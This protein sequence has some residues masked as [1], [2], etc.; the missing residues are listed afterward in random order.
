MRPTRQSYRGTP[1]GHNAD[2]IYYRLKEPA[3]LSKAIALEEGSTL[4]LTF[5]VVDTVSGEP[6]FPQQALL[7]FEDQRGDDVRLP[8]TVKSNGKASFTIV[9]T[10]EKT[11]WGHID[12]MNRTWRNRLLRYYRPK[13]DSTLHCFSRL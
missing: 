7:L 12:M 11:S 8:V 6:V 10:L 9:S 13:G 1:Q 4:K 2:V 5:G 3:P